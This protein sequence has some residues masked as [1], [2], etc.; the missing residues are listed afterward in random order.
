M[1]MNAD[2]SNPQVLSNQQGAYD[3]V[4]S[5]DGRQIAYDADNDGD[6]W[7]EL[8][9]MNADGSNQ[10]MI[11]NPS[12]DVVAWAR[13][14]SPDGRYLAFSEIALVFYQGNWYWTTGRV[15][16]WDSAN[17]GSIQDLT[18]GD[19]E[20]K[21]D[22]E[23]SDA[24]A[25]TSGVQALP[26]QSP[27][28]FTVRWSGADSGGAGLKDYDVQVK[29]GA[30]GPW[31]TW[32][33]GV[34]ASNASYPG[35]GGHTYYFRS[36]ARDNAFNSE[37]WPANYD[38]V[39]T[40]ESLPPQTSVAALPEYSRNGLEVRWGGVDPGG[41]GIKSYDVQ[42]RQ[43]N[44]PWTNWKTNTT[45][46]AATFTGAAGSTIQFRVRARD[47]AQN[48]EAWPASADATTVLYTWGIS[49][50]V[51]DNRGAPVHGDGSDDDAGR[52]PRPGQRR[53]RRLCGPCDSQCR[54]LYR[55]LEQGWLW[56]PAGHDH[57][58]ASTLTR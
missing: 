3:P 27:G 9:L 8:W 47:N 55:S 36:R 16:V 40:V 31:T 14:W 6:N 41:S 58:I 45:D 30:N 5:P 23:T 35:V 38:A 15:R 10:R 49:G 46:T 56:Q 33:A 53:R 28:P 2:G 4:W 22:L 20:W 24:S 43:D 7:E 13:S 34:T 54:Q 37:A 1:V 32:Q 50:V 51:T 11:Y 26:A 52:L 17:P 12:G 57:L 44:G 42:T 19:R 39:T 21:P 18:P 25:P 29:D 48:L